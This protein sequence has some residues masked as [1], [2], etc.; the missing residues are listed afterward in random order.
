M[1]VN[2][3]DILMLYKDFSESRALLADRSG[4]V[5]RAVPRNINIVRISERLMADN[6]RRLAVCR[7]K[8]GVKPCKLTVAQI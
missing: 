8:L 3:N 6:K 2:I 5:N 1:T 7:F 4:T